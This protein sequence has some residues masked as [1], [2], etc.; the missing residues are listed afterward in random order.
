MKIIQQIERTRHIA[1]LRMRNLCSILWD[2]I[3]QT[4]TARMWGDNYGR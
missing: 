2:G 3:M 1:P 4:R